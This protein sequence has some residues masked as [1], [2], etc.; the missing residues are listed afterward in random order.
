MS[1]HKFLLSRLF[2]KKKMIIIIIEK[3]KVQ[4]TK[5]QLVQKW[6]QI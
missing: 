4:R 2:V 5:C 3:L 6:R 1:S